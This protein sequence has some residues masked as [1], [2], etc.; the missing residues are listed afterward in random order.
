MDKPVSIWP[1]IRPWGSAGLEYRLDFLETPENEYDIRP[2]TG[3]I[4][5]G[6]RMPNAES[7]MPYI[8]T[9]ARFPRKARKQI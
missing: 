2:D 5:A 8:G 3:Y 9:S 6:C 7:R 1:D 4:M